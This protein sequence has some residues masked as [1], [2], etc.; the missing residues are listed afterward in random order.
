MSSN[1]KPFA[2]TKPFN[3]SLAD[4]YILGIQIGSH[5]DDAG[6]P[7]MMY[8]RLSKLKAFIR[9]GF[10]ELWH[11]RGEYNSLTGLPTDNAVSDYF[12]CT[13]TF[14]EDGKTFFKDRLYAWNGSQWSDISDV[15]TEYVKY[16]EFEALQDEVSEAKGDI[17]DIKAD[18]TTLQN[19]VSDL[20][21]YT[22]TGFKYKGEDTYANIMA[23]VDMEQGDMWYATDAQKY[24]AYNGTSWDERPDLGLFWVADSDGDEKLCIE[25]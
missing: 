6:L 25:I 11:Y 13:G 3:G 21:S 23:L 18:V 12:L 16:S 14:T 1:L 22:I 7:E 17:V 20:Q 15:L 8:I 5:T 2:N 9:E 4:D 24:Y 19:Q 10:G